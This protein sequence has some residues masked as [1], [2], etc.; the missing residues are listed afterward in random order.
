M[1]RRMM[2]LLSIAVLAALL[3]A[4]CGTGSREQELEQ[5]VEQLEQ[6]ITDLQNAAGN[7]ANTD[8]ND[9]AADSSTADTAT[10]NRTD[11]NTG[12]DDFET[13]SKKISDAVTQAD[14]AKPTGTA[15]ADRKLF[16]EQKTA[17]DTL[18]RELDVYED[19]LEAQYRKGTL[20]YEDFRKQDRE[21]EKL[22]DN[23]DDAEDRLENRFGIDD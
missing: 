22:E 23:L 10:D 7:T 15:D 17:L 21:I 20:S 18:D 1:K 6:Q 2:M 3:L 16:F 12:T 14:A 13:L 5:Q 11:T 4:G 19:N 8:A 9:T